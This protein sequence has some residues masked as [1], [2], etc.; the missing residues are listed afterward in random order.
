M[1]GP[2]VRKTSPKRKLERLI[3]KYC[4]WYYVKSEPK[5][6]DYEFDMLFKK[7]QK[8]EEN[9]GTHPKSPTQMVYGD[10]EDQ[11]SDWVREIPDTLTEIKRE[12]NHPLKSDDYIEIRHKGKKIKA[13]VEYPF[14]TDGSIM[15]IRIEEVI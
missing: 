5:I 4:Y 14:T 11:Y 9:G 3:I 1:A 13:Q 8:M 15:V 12:P 2:P 7:L 6:S 10:C